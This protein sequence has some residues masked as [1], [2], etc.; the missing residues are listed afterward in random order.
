MMSGRFGALVSFSLDLVAAPG[1]VT[2]NNKRRDA[3]CWA[4]ALRSH[5]MLVLGA[6]EGDGSIFSRIRPVD[7]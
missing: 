4:G 3:G 2:E 6:G 5:K 1:G 7:E